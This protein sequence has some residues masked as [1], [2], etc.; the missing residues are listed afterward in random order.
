M[1]I[2]RRF[3]GFDA[4]PFTLCKQVDRPRAVGPQL[5]TSGTWRWHF[6]SGD[7]FVKTCHRLF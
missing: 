7:G 5:V 1:E 3:T 2:A 4:V 6:E